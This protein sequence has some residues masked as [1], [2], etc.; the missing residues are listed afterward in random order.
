MY[1]FGT[2]SSTEW[3]S[4]DMSSA[5]RPTRFVDISST[6]ETK[7]AALK[8]C[9]AEMRPFP[10]SRSFQAAEHLARLRDSSVGLEAVEAFHVIREISK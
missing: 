2:L 5:F 3:A 1:G 4:S 8:C 10:H 9:E 6:L 7:Q